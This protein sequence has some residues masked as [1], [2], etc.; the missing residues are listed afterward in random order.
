MDRQGPTLPQQKIIQHVTISY[1][2][3]FEADLRFIVLVTDS[4]PTKD[5]MF[6]WRH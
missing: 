4:Y 2:T 1:K 3:I 6:I 5:I